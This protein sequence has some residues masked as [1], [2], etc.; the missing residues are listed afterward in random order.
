MPNR[1]GAVSIGTEF[2]R[3]KGMY[4]IG[5]LSKL[6]SI[7]VKTLRFYDA[8]GL[9]VPDEIDK[10]TG[11]RYYSA[12]KLDEC[13]R[14]IALKELG[15]SLDEIRLQLAA[16]SN[17]M[18]A[19]C[20]H[21]KMTA[22]KEQME[23]TQKQLE[24]IEAI[25]QYFTE[26]EQKMF[27]VIIRKTENMHIA[28][29]RQ[30]FENKTDAIRQA[31][32]I[33]DALPRTMVGKRRMLI[34]YECEYKEHDLDI[35]ACV[36]I[37]EALPANTGFGEKTVTFGSTA[38]LICKKEE[39]DDAYKAMIQYIDSS[40]YQI[41]GASYE[42]YYDD[43]TTELKV[44]VCELEKAE[45][46]TI[47]DMKK[48]FT[49]DPNVYGMWKVVDIVPAREQFIYGKPKCSHLYE[50]HTL[51]FIDGG[52]P[53][54][55]IAGW[56]KGCLYMYDTK[57]DTVYKNHYTVEMI[58]GH[59]LLFLEMYDVGSRDDGFC[60]KEIWVYEKTEEKH[61]TSKEELRKCDRIDYP[62]VD[63]AQIKGCWKVRDFV[64]CKEDFDTEKQNWKKEN[65][66]VLAVEFR[67]DG[68]YEITTKNGTNAVTSTWTKG[69]V[70]NKREQTA[71]AY[72]IKVIDGKEYLF[73]EWKSGDYSFGGGRINWYVFVRG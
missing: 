51:C 2:E 1:K 49:D 14:I 66:F 57:K 13:Y 31:E 21:T 65:L 39:L 32:K 30:N 18:I 68:V 53:Y 8:E 35:A 38:S 11:Y 46:I 67:E 40:S 26:G 3:N 17:E 10:F 62:F 69:L 19:A 27:H 54:W 9:L 64:R 70:L 5:E 23:R 41:C 33:A 20:L 47:D 50:P 36:E 72:E 16:E 42:I 12:A 43:G 29:I 44:P 7:P 61:Y 4:K 6:C 71:S 22:L 25:H 59:M 56:S 34:N 45:Y 37:T 58:N 73:L 63:D 15:F 24:R 52:K 48:S 28:W 60:T 55:I